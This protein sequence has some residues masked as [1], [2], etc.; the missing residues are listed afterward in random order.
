MCEIYNIINGMAFEYLR[1]TIKEI[2]HESRSVIPL[3]QPKVRT[4][5]YGKEGIRYEGA[6]SF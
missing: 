3:D 5:L 1:V 4:V 2:P 6:R